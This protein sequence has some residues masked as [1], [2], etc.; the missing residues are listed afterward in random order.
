M[1][2]AYRIVISDIDGTL[3]ADDG[4]LPSDNRA[5][6]AHFRARGVRTCLATGRRWA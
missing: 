6:L 2:L 1:S 3:L 4:R 5:A